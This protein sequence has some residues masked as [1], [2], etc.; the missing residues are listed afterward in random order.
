M[1]RFLNFI[2]GKL[3]KI[4]RVNLDNCYPPVNCDI[5]ELDVETLA[6]ECFIEHG[7]L[8]PESVYKREIAIELAKELIPYIKYETTEDIYHDGIRYRGVIKIV[9]ER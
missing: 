1:K 3:F 9:K 4:P 6:Y 5:T 2:I 8:I 7:P